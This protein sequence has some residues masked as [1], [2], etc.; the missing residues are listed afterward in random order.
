MALG[1]IGSGFLIAMVGAILMRKWSVVGRYVVVLGATLILAGMVVGVAYARDI[2][3]VASVIDGDTLEIHGERIRLYGI[4]AP[5]SS[6]RCYRSDGE[7]W[8]CGQRAAEELSQLAGR[9]T[10]LCQSDEDDRYGRA[11]AVCFVRSTDINGAMVA[12]GYAVAYRYY[13]ER[14]VGPEQEAKAEERGV[15]SSRFVMPWEYRRGKR[16]HASDA[17]GSP[18]HSCAIKGNIGKSG[19]RTYH[20]PGDRHY[21]VTRIDEGRG[22]RWFCTPAEAEAARWRRGPQ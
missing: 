15:W 21:D 16:F 11:I 8:R 7:A 10:V 9:H 5:E 20:M 6:Q 14:Y 19:N 17:P 12:A 3:G 13:S 18:S 22:E 2:S 1:I 4:D